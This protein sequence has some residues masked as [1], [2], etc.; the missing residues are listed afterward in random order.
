MVTSHN[1]EISW[2]A[3]CKEHGARANVEIIL[4]ARSPVTVLSGSSEVEKLK[5]VMREI[6]L[7]IQSQTQPNAKPR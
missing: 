6:Y 3:Q 7:T 1:S 2:F 4:K 5:D